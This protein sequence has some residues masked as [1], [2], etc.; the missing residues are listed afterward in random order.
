MLFC[1][2]SMAFGGH[3]WPVERVGLDQVKGYE[4]RMNPAM[5]LSDSGLIA[6]ERRECAGP[7]Y[8]P[9]TTAYLD[10]KNGTWTIGCGHTGPEVHQGLVWTLDQCREA[11]RKDLAATELLLNSSL[12]PPVPL[13]QN[14]YDALV[15]F[16]FWAGEGNWRKSTVLK[17]VNAG[18]LDQVPSAL[19]MW[20]YANGDYSKPNEGVKNRRLSEIGQWAQGSFVSSATGAASPP[21]G[22]LTQMHNRLAAAGITSMIGALTDSWTADTFTNA[23]Q[24]LQ[25]LSPQSKIFA[26]LGVGLIVLGVVWRF[27][28]ARQG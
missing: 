3:Q 21:P 9:E 17:R 5:H 19:Q 22:I 13:R 27:V 16:A 8:T 26:A 24:T 11:L 10:G 18:K 23:G 2:Y 15:S 7:N 1:A 6:L 28:K 25:G 12:N 20:V 4:V 14:Q